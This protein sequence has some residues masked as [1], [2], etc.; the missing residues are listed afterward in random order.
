M[1]T[2]RLT[3]EYDGTP[4][5]GWQS[6]RNRSDCMTVQGAL[7]AAIFKLTGVRSEVRGASRTDAG[8]HAR[9][10]VAAFDTGR[11]EIPLTGFERGLTRYLPPEIVVRRAQWVEPGWN[12]RRSARGKRYRYTYWLGSSPP[13]LDRHRAWFVK[14]ALS[15]DTMR[16]GAKCLL[17]THDFGAFRSSG[18]SAK[19]AVRTLYGVALHVDGA[20]RLVLEVLGNAFVRNMV[21]IMAGN[22]YEVGRGRFSVSDLRAILRSRDR[23]Q[24]G[25][26]APAHGLCLEEIIYDDRLPPRPKEN[27]DLVGRRSSA[28]SPE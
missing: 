27:V 1:R 12:P 21:R 9:G 11:T 22:L 23:T 8:V 28:G 5:H 18:C 7:E 10:Q 16:E 15:V 6:Q 14:S 26:T 19:H 2:I 20:E 25:V 24:G 4:F 3:L 17:G 13:A